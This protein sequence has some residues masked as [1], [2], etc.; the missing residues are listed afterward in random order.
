MALTLDLF[1]LRS[2][3]MGCDAFGRCTECGAEYL[4][5]GCVRCGNNTVVL[6]GYSF[7]TIPTKEL[8]PCKDCSCSGVYVDYGGPSYIGG[9][10]VPCKSCNGSG[11]VTK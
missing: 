2:K 7:D 5:G 8:I 3:G 4:T 9:V 6:G 10:A 1:R 11:W